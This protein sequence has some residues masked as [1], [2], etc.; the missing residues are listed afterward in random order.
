MVMREP[1]MV[2]LTEKRYQRPP[3][4]HSTVMGRSKVSQLVLCVGWRLYQCTEKED[5]GHHCCSGTED[6]CKRSS[7][8]L[9]WQETRMSRQH[10]CLSHQTGRQQVKRVTRQAEQTNRRA[11]QMNRSAEQINQQAILLRL[12]H[13]LRAL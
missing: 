13:Q 5:H 11:E 2:R 6:H 10:R 9:H 8:H 4:C 7:K 3:R 1:K 12:G